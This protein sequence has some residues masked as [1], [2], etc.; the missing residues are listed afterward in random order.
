MSDPDAEHRERLAQTWAPRPGVLGWLS[1]VNHKAIA[2]RY[3]VTA[4]GFFV[5]AGLLALVMR[6]QLARPGA[7]LVGPDLYNQI[8][9][10]HGSTM[11]FLFAVPVM[12]AMGLYLVPMMIGTRNV[13]FP[14]MNAFG[15]YV[16]LIGGLFL[17][18]G[19]ALNIGAD[20]GWFSYVPLA[21][22]DYSPGKRAD[23][24]A[25][26]ITF[27]ELAALVA[28]IEIIVTTFKQRAPGMTLDRIPIVVWAMVVTSFMII[29]AMPAV[30]VSSGM[31]A[32]D[33]LI[34]TQFFNPAEGGDVLLWQHLFWFFGHPEVYIIFIP[35][36]GFV[37][38]IVTTFSRRSVFG[39]LA[40]VLSLVATGFLAFGLWVHHMFAVGLPEM[41]QGFFTAA[42]MMI[43]IPNGVQIFCCL[44]TLIRGRL[45]FRTPLLFVLGFIVIFVAGGLTG[46]MLAAVPFD[47]QVHDTY[48][49]VAHF[50]YVLVGGAVFPLLGAFYYWLPKMTGRRLSEKLGQAS[51][52]LLFVG[53]NLT[54]FPMH[55]L[56]LVGMPRRIYTYL[57]D[58]GWGGLNLLST[59]GAFIIAAAVT[60]FAV[61]VLWSLRRGAP[62]GDDPWGAATLEWSTPSPPPTYNFVRIPVVHSRY[63]RWAPLAD[64]MVTT[65]LRDDLREVVITSMLDAEPTTR[66]LLD[67]P[68]II[69][70][71]TAL[72]VGVGL[73]AGIFTP[74]GFVIGAALVLPCLVAWFWPKGDPAREL[75]EG[76]A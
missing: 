23:I 37:S 45:L 7:H 32:L 26:M 68:T 14:R 16:Y 60:A 38:A 9:T 19:L 12:E 58:T 69:P 24:W 8:F 56:G 1:E 17:W 43:A 33:R 50:H 11:M 67:G 34:D 74:W 48:F 71:L 63:P 65:G 44:A 39:Y 5:L 61:N 10:V 42:S 46:V 76:R 64:P 4:M 27:T 52:W 57:P 62:A 2:L 66:H 40:L 36:T 35:A 70:L 55:Q 31:L 72:A 21:G 53:F 29:F 15:Y 49:V 22:P 30:M 13:A 18:V 75:A 54:F 59:V 73:I 25:Q 41:G 47:L 3:M 28:A 6:L 20:V 51:F